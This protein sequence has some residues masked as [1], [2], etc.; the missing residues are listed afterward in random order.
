MVGEPTVEEDCLN[1]NYWGTESGGINQ[2]EGYI[3]PGHAP[4]DPPV[5]LNFFQLVS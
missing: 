5:G 1:Y 4:N 3:L 2:G